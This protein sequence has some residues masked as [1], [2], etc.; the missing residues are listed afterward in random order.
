MLSEAT[1]D[2]EVRPFSHVDGTARLLSKKVSSKVETVAYLPGRKSGIVT[3]EGQRVFNTWREGR[4][5]PATNYKP[6]D[7]EP[8][9]DFMRHLIPIDEERNEVL[10]WVATLLA[11]P[12]MRMQYGVLLV[13]EEQGVGKG[14]LGE[15]ILAP[16]VGN[17]NVS[18][19]D[20]TMIESS[21]NYWAAHK[22]LAVVHEIYAGHSRRLYDKLKSLITDG[23]I[24]VSR[25]FMAEYVIDNHLHVFACSNS[26]N[27]LA[28]DD[29]D[30]RWLVPRVTEDRRDK[31]YW[32]E[33]NRR[34]DE[35]NG[36]AIVRRRADEFQ[37]PCSGR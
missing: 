9:L 8:L 33:L 24:T 29:K 36:L 25:K 35:E 5:R 23:R 17:E 37:P 1:F 11:R 28:I 26:L 7:A 19:P 12:D 14:T 3:H 13:S 27:A 20:E 4:I 21:F 32:R 22:R 30:R 31:E 2:G 15:K 16:L 6:E 34:L 18:F 10:R